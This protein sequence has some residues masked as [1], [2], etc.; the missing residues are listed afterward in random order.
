MKIILDENKRI[1]IITKL[2]NFHKLKTI[3]DPNQSKLSPGNFLKFNYIC[4][5]NKISLNNSFT[6]N[7]SFLLNLYKK[8]KDTVFINLVF[9]LA[10]FFFKELKDKNI[11]KIDKFYEDK[12]YV[13]DNLNKFFTFNLSQNS[14]INAINSKLNNG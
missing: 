11:I 14:L 12:A 13:L 10:D 5:E 8:N 1:E 6:D 3:L 2:V 4:H 9:Y 7:L